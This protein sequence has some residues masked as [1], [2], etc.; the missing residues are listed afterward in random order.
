MKKS[1]VYIHVHVVRM[2]ELLDHRCLIQQMILDGRTHQDI[3]QHLTSLGIKHALAQTI[4][5]FCSENEIN[6]R[7]RVY[8]G[9]FILTI[10]WLKVSNLT[11]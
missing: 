4:S 11:C 6:R 7:C 5:R 1:L 2:E 3:S 8:G 10:S 9:A